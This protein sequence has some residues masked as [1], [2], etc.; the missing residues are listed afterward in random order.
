MDNTQKT[1]AS[2]VEFAGRVVS[3]IPVDERASVYRSLTVLFAE[4]ADKFDEEL[5]CKS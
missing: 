2:I 5:S 4:Q 1:T 3:R